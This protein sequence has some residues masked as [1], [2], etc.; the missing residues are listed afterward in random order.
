[1]CSDITQNVEI[2]PE[3][4]KFRRLLEILKEWYVQRS[5]L[6]LSAQIFTTKHVLGMI[7]ATF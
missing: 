6:I 4:T 3:E 7:K 2:R 1:V 5:N